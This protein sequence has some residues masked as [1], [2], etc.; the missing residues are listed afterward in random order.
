MFV[1]DSAFHEGPTVCIR[2]VSGHYQ[3]VLGVKRQWCHCIFA[4]C[5]Q[6][7]LSNTII[8]HTNRDLFRLPNSDGV[9]IS[10][11]ENRAVRDA[12][13]LYFVYLERDAIYY[14]N[15]AVCLALTAWVVSLKFRCRTQSRRW[16]NLGSSRVSWNESCQEGCARRWTGWV[17]SSRLLRIVER[18][19]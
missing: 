2:Y 15:N 9:R 5:W 8:I 17:V 12:V 6:L 10:T 4:S 16:F 7:A 3:I 19:L 1:S 18:R 11:H 13:I 14:K